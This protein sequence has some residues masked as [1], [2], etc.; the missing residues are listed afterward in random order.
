MLSVPVARVLIGTWQ[1]DDLF[2]LVLLRADTGRWEFP[3]GKI[4]AEEKA[5]DAA[6]REV[7]EETGISLRGLPQ[8]IF[9]TNPKHMTKDR[10]SVE[11]YFCTTVESARAKL[12]PWHTDYMWVTLDKLRKMDAGGDLMPSASSAVFIMGGLDQY[13]HWPMPEMF[14]IGPVS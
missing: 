9:Y 13:A 5:V 11:L 1:L 6:H 14:T 10:H 2:F 4:E 12:E 3:G 8:F 7:E